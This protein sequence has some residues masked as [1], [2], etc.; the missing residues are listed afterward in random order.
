M[1]WTRCGIAGDELPGIFASGDCRSRT[2]K[3]VTLAVGDGALAVPCV[4][5]YPGTSA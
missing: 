5:D 3:H 2:I 4:H 1:R